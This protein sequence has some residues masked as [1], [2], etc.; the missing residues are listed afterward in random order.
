MRSGI[1]AALSAT[2]VITEAGKIMARQRAPRRAVAAMP[3]RAAARP[4]AG[5]ADPAGRAA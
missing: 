2:A 5:V 3:R 1:R 4:A